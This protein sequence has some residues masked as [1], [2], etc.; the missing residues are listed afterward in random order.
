[1]V[2][3]LFFNPHWKIWFLLIFLERGGG[4]VEGETK[5]QTERE[6]ESKREENI[7]VREKD[8][9]VASCTHPEIEPTT[10]QCT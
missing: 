2:F 10:Y 3:V 5:R 1:M 7:N 6:T 9:S 4:G 8:Q